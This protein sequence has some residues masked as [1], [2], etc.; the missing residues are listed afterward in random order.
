MAKIKICGDALV[1]ESALKTETLKVVE[2][3]RPEAVRIQDEKGNVV[4]K[5]GTTDGKGTVNEFGVSFNGTSRDEAGLATVTMQIPP[6]VTDAVQYAE[7]TIGMSVLKLNQVEDAVMAAYEG[8]A[9]DLE[10]VRSNI[11]ML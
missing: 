7:D 3:Y 2:R 8:V 4:F 5:I 6:Y 10:M 11:E 9:A 1:L